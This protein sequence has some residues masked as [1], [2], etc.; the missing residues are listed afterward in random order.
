MKRLRNIIILL[1]IIFTCSTIAAEVKS[2]FTLFNNRTIYEKAGESWE[3]IWQNGLVLDIVFY[4][5]VMAFLVL[6]LVGLN[7]YKKK[8]MAKLAEKQAQLDS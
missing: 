7:V 1:M 2:Y 5:V 4:V 6:A 8:R 3:G